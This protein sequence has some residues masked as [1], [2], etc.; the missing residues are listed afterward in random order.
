MENKDIYTK[1]EKVLADDSRTSY[2]ISQL[3]NI[4]ANNI[5]A[6]R[7]GKRKIENM[8][9]KNAILLADLYDETDGQ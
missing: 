7:K 9:L 4:P 5:D 6:F 8:S 2:R 3:T 1:I